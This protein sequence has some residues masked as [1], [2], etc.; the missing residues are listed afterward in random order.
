MR[1]NDKLKNIQEANKKLLGESIPDEIQDRLTTLKS[2]YGLTDNGPDD[3]KEIAFKIWRHLSRQGWG[4][5][6]DLNDSRNHFE[7][8]WDWY[9]KNDEDYY[10]AGGNT[11]GPEGW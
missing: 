3:C 2:Q 4:N 11:P 8:M 9:S 10:D 6:D 1:K 7:K 5:E